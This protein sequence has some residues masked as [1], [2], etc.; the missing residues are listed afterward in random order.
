MAIKN[1]LHS[2]SKILGKI[3]AQRGTCQVVKLSFV[4]LPVKLGSKA[5]RNLLRMHAHCQQTRPITP[6]RCQPYLCHSLTVAAYLSH[7]PR[8]LPRCGRCPNWLKNMYHFETCVPKD[9]SQCPFSGNGYAEP[10]SKNRAKTRENAE[11]A[12]RL[13]RLER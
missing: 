3:S 10:R 1:G 4:I 6:Q 8:V 5:R 2:V 11:I 7:G 12:G 13:A 9:G